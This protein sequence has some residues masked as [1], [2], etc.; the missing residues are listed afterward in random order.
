MSEQGWQTVSYK[1]VKKNKSIIVPDNVLND[2]IISRQKE[3]INKIN[4][5]N[6]N[7]NQIKYDC[8]KDTNQDWN[9][10]NIVKTKPKPKVSLPQKQS[11]SIKEN[12]TTGD[13]SI[14]RVSKSMAKSIVD[15]RLSKKWT[16]LQ[17]AQNSTVDV[18]TINEIERGGCVYNANI[19]NKLCKTLG[20]KIE[21]NYDTTQA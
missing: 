15:A 3:A 11:T 20:V 21:R 9:Y 13:V 1:K 6:Q 17:L 16:Q 4:T 2:P 10:V 12:L 19:F 8:P 7:K 5:Q 18:K 14:K